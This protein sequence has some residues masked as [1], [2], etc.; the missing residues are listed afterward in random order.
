M[1]NPHGAG[2]RLRVAGG[3]QL[4]HG[5]VAA[6]GAGAQRGGAA[7]RRQR[8]AGEARGGPAHGG[9]AAAAL[10]GRA[11]GGGRWGGVGRGAQDA[12]QRLPKASG[13]LVVSLVPLL[14][15]DFCGR[16]FNVTREVLSVV[17]GAQQASGASRRSTHP[18]PYAGET[19]FTSPTELFADSGEQRQVRLDAAKSLSL[20]GPFAGYAL[21]TT[22]DTVAFTASDQVLQLQAVQEMTVRAAGAMPQEGTGRHRV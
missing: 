1:S 6:D 22:S 17:R 10:P 15:L 20:V 9:H 21:R 11:P 2:G 8:R 4:P 3:A 5:G 13:P 12:E 19:L 7:G 18:R 16:L 14:S